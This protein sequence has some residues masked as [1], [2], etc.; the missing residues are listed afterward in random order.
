MPKSTKPSQAK[1]RSTPTTKVDPKKSPRPKA[2]PTPAKPKRDTSK[3]QREAQQQQRVIRGVAAGILIALLVIITGLI[4]D[5]L[6]I[7]SRVVAQVND[8]ELTRR[9]YWQEY[10]DMLATQIVQ[11]L[12][13]VAMFGDNEQFG[14]QFKGRTPLINEQVTT[15]HSEETDNQQVIDMWKEDQ[16]IIQGAQS[17][18]IQATTDEVNQSIVVDMGSVFLPPDEAETPDSTEILT[19]TMDVVTDTLTTDALTETETLPTPDGPPPT[20]TPI[21]TPEPAVAN[22]KVSQVFAKVADMF[23]EELDEIEER[24]L[25]PRFTSDDFL[26]AMQ[27]RYRVQLYTEQIQE[28]LVPEDTFEPST[29][30][31]RV[32]AHHILLHVDVPITLTQTMTPTQEISDTIDA[33]YEERLSEAEEIVQEL[34]DGADFEA[35]VEEYSEDP[36]SKDTG[37]DVGTFDKEGASAQGATYDPAFVEAAFELEVDAISDPVR[38]QFGWHIIQ[39][40][41]WITNSVEQQLQEARTEAFDEWLE[42]QR[43]A[44]TIQQFPQPSPTPTEQPSPTIEPTYMPGPPTAQPTPTPTPGA[45]ATST[46]PL[47]ETL[48]TMEEEEELDNTEPL[49]DTNDADDMDENEVDATDDEEELDN[50]E[51]LTDINDADNTETV[52]E[53]DNTEPL[54]DTDDA[55]DTDDTE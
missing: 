36:G 34:R 19:D 28:Q 17:M 33:A 23:Q 30:P 21:P 40:T 10:R 43:E 42:E 32:S 50:T 49:T 9:A 13:M 12:Q 31:E 26:T 22:E 18:N 14:S 7:P 1:G 5:Q 45:D 37:G 47:I 41:E 54:T 52:D 51:P 27:T 29:E 11:S 15:I 38:T 39:V 46:P 25:K 6:W 8:A 48:T 55:D 35:M 24:N 4:Y 2:A 16:L 53:V 3:S 20:N 44:A